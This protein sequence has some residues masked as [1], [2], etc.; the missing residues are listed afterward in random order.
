MN[1]KKPFHYLK[2]A[3]IMMHSNLSLIKNR[4]C[5][6]K[7]NVYNGIKFPST[8]N[9][10]DFSIEIEN[11]Y[12]PKLTITKTYSSF[13][14]TYNGQT[15][16]ICGNIISTFYNKSY[17]VDLSDIDSKEDMF[18]LST[19]RDFYDL[20]YNDVEASNF[21][22]SELTSTYNETLLKHV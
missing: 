8:M 19:V 11:D 9:E 21:L 10:P 6:R 2:I 16:S 12:L 14:I 3:L 7:H 18:T 22:I 20:D 15:Y 13:N 1:N 17:I 4:I 5:T